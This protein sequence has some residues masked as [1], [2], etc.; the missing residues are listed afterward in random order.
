[1]QRE[2]PTRRDVLTS[3]FSFYVGGQTETEWTDVIMGRKGRNA[4]MADFSN[5][6]SYVVGPICY[7][8]T[9]IRFAK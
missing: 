6:I 7:Y 8:E 1:M 9:S 4:D 5:F 2:Q 3:Q